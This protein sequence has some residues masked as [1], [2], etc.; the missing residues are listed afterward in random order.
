MVKRETAPE[1][2]ECQKLLDKLM[3][4]PE[5]VPFLEPVPWKDLGLTDYPKVVKKPMDFGTMKKKLVDNS[6]EAATDFNK[7]LKQVWKNCM[8]YNADGSDF[9]KLAHRWDKRTE[10]DMSRIIKKYNLSSTTT[11]STS[12]STTKIKGP[13][14]EE[15]A[16]FCRMMYEV[17]E[18]QLGKIVKTLDDICEAALDKT[19]SDEVEINVD[20][21][22]LPTFKKVDALIKEFVN[23]NRTKKRAGVESD[24]NDTKKPKP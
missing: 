9:F 16:S 5:L 24:A 22:D 17:N 23:Q 14:I 2:L 3:V 6:Y 1:M 12:T 11:S 13:S 8:T 18:N 15:K 7:D 4:D 20:A 19:N 10:K 21:I